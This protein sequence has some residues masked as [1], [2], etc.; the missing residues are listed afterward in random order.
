MSARHRPIERIL[1]RLP[2]WLGD[3][4][5]ARPLAH[6]LRAAHPAARIVAY[7]P[8]GV[9]DLLAAERVWD[10]QRPWPIAGGAAHEDARWDAA[11]ILPPSF[12][13]AWHAFR[14]GARERVGFSGDARDWLLTHVVRRGA[15]GDRHLAREFLD[16]GACVGAGEA[17]AHMPDLPVPP[18]DGT[19][20]EHAAAPYAVLAPGAIYGPA[21]R[22]PIEHFETLARAFAARGWKVL[23]CG[24]AKEAEPCAAL[25]SRTGAVSLAGR[26]TLG[27]QAALCAGAEVVVSND[28]GL[29][30]LAGAV[31]S[32]TIAIFGSTSSSWTAPLGRRV[33]VV[34]RPPVCSPCFARTC[35]IGYACLHA[36]SPGS[37][38]DAAAELAA[39]SREVEA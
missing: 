23:A 36:V 27:Q 24:G 39:G 19:L 3:A 15:R 35:R 34:Q 28:S 38:L 6:A 33:R 11:V 10:E 26:T 18:L 29:A 2:N 31:G 16:L 8:A 30:H 4:L 17:P 12:S 21:K 5:M 22:W 7:G 13:S 1:F 20:R 14:A 37:V 25:E 9:L 32:P